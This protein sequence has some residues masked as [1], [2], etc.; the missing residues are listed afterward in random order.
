MKKNKLLLV[1][2]VLGVAYLIYSI[3]YWGG[4][5]TSSTGDSAQAG[6]ALATVL[7]MP[8][9][10][11]TVLAVIFNA[12]GF[13]M[14]KRAFALTAGILYTVAL[15]LFPPYFMF[16]IVQMILCFVAFAKMKKD[17]SGTSGSTE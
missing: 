14:S 4:A 6:A 8:H 13:F 16:V 2:L 17:A 12:L 9:L 7:V 15:V 11:L 5:N 3:V 10:A 1:A